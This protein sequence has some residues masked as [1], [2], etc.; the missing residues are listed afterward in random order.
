M[1][2]GFTLV[3]VFT[4]VPFAGNQLC[5][6]PEPPDDLGSATMQVL[7]REIGFSE[8]TYV[9]AVREGGYDVRI[10]T[11]VSELR[12]AGHPTLGTA[13]T[14]VRLG[15][16]P[17]SVVQTSTAG[18]VPVEVDLGAGAATMRQLPAEFG[19]PF[20][21][22]GAV[23]RAAGVEADDLGPGPI[24]PVS[25]G[26]IHLM[27]PVVGEDALRRASRDDRGCVTVCERAGVESLYLFAVR[28]RGDVMARMFDRSAEIGEDAATGSAAG[29]LGAYLSEHDA[30]GMPGHVT[31]AQGEM[32][33]RPSFI[34]VD[35]AR[36]DAGW[37]AFVGGGVQIVGE[38]SFEL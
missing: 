30:G 37:V 14:L 18:D 1:R 25:T 5:V 16:V 22:R 34:E 28:G 33:G 2:V 35:V 24:A 20:D 17:A 23:A 11:P 9:T 38:G 27:V 3:D 15:V 8:T 29:P 26:I 6:V 12:F 7:A 10:F 31:I 19:E 32:I 13:F 36:H 4:D 21:D